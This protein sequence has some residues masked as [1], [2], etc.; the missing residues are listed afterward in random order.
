MSECFVSVIHGQDRLLVVG[1]VRVLLLS[2][3][4]TSRHFARK[5]ACM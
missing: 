2:T 3:C 1:L 5:E 4:P